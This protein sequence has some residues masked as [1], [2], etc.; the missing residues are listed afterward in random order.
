[1][2]ADG[3]RFGRPGERI[4]RRTKDRRAQL[5]AVMGRERERLVEAAPGSPEWDAARA[6]LDE[7]EWKL[8]VLDGP[9][10]DEEAI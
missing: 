7:L 2:Q 1:M 10:P 5:I 4:T 6:A 8:T 9:G 3:A